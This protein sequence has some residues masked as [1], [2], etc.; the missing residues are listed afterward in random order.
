MGR[1]RASLHGFL[2][3]GAD[4]DR[5]DDLH[6]AIVAPFHLSYGPNQTFFLQEK[7]KVE[8]NPLE[9]DW[10][11]CW[12]WLRRT[13]NSSPLV[14]VFPDLSERAV[15]PACRFQGWLAGKTTGGPRV[16]LTVEVH[17]LARA[18]GASLPKEGAGG[19][20]GSSMGGRRGRFVAPQGRRCGRSGWLVALG[21]GGAGG[22]GGSSSP[23]EG[24]GGKSSAGAGGAGARPQGRRSRRDLGG[25]FRKKEER[26]PAGAGGAR[27]AAPK[28]GGAGG[29]VARR[30]R[31][32][33]ERQIFTGGAGV[34]LALHR[35]RSRRG[36]WFVVSERRRRANLQPARG[37]AG[38]SS[39][40]K[41]S[42]RGRWLSSPCEGGAAS[43]PARAE[44]VARRS[45]SKEEHEGP[46]VRRLRKEGVR[47]DLR[48]EREARHLRKRVSG[49]RRLEGGAGGSFHPKE[50]GE[51][52]SEGFSS[53]AM[54]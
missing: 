43:S 40:I 24:G 10:N 33:E 13:G 16:P 28:E 8:P 48:A 21:E 41:R 30:L 44:R 32:K 2:I 9:K 25:R 11:L 17:R 1:Y 35:R 51:G 37:G 45:P 34:A 53:F 52:K 49:N 46:V 29:P 20:G 38:G 50:G 39:L 4:R 5:T 18:A 36:R 26:Q 14:F 15:C 27:L 42:R 19:A 6:N 54:E 22:A 23:K 47:A 3:G 31:K 12:R 7:K